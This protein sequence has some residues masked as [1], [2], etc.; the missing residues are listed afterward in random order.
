MEDS[1]SVTDLAKDNKRTSYSLAKSEQEVQKMLKQKLQISNINDYL[2]YFIE[3][4][5]EQTFEI[6]FPQV[7]ERILK[8]C[9]ELKRQIDFIDGRNFFQHLAQI[10]GLE[11]EIWILIEMCT[12]VDSEGVAIFSE[13]E[14]L[15]IAQNDFKTYFKEKCGMNIL[16]TPPHSLHFLTE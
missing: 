11:S 12:I 10:N 6:K 1:L 15:T 8:N 9:S 16:N 4:A 13:E 14:I 2:S 3:K 7:K 5:N